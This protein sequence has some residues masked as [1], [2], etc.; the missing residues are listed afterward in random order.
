LTTL[1]VL[2]VII[3]IKAIVTD[4][5]NTLL[6][7]NK[8][9]SDYTVNILKR[10]QSAGVK[11]VFATARSSQAS[12]KLLNR[13]APDV[14]VGYGGALVMV[15]DSVIHR[16]DISSE[17]SNMLI[18][19]CLETPAVIAIYAINEKIAL[20]NKPTS[21]MSHY[22]YTDFTMESKESF[23]KI[24]LYAN[25]PTAVENIASRFPMCDMLR[26]TGENLYR[27]ANRDAV[28]WKAVQTI[29]EYFDYGTDA[30]VVFGDDI[31]DIE[32][33]QKYGIGVAVTNA[34]Q[35]LKSVADYICDT[36]DN[37]GVAKWL[38]ENVL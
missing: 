35:K 13:F 1:S 27:F 18:K 22:Q 33:V 34:I 10:C 7:N 5:D 8:T 36:N 25:N 4:L 9:I 29:S 6:R 2:E 38:E 32:M 12:S 31:N 30:F 14:F 24:S 11:V 15:L 37:D 20:S 26:Y 3:L 28:K 16:F 21:D 23:L 19:E 17:I